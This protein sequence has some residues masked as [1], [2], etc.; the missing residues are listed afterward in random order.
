MH[1]IWHTIQRNRG[2]NKDKDK[3]RVAIKNTQA[4]APVYADINEGRVKGADHRI[5]KGAGRG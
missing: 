4:E 5:R 2:T 3:A 1:V